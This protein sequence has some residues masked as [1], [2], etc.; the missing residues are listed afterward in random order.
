M[1]RLTFRKYNEANWHLCKEGKIVKGCRIYTIG[2]VVK[3]TYVATGIGL[4]HI[5][6]NGYYLGTISRTEH[7]NSLSDA[8]RWLA[9]E[10]SKTHY[11]EIKVSIEN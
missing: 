7:F 4:S 9:D 6:N 11:I 1:P 5:Y 3:T 2:T 8:K 10:Y